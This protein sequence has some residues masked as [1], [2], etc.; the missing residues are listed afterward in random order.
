MTIKKAYE[1]NILL[2]FIFQ[3]FS[4]FYMIKVINTLFFQK[5]G[6]SIFQIGILLAIYQGSK[7]I[8]EVPTG[9]LADRYG[10]K[11]SVIIGLILFEIF[12]LATFCFRTFTGFFIAN[13]IQGI[14]ITFLTGALDAI[15]VDSA[16]LVGRKEKL[17]KYNSISRV[18]FFVALGLS[19]LIGGKIAT[20]SY[21]MVFEIT[22][23]IQIIPILLML[24]IKEPH[25]YEDII[26]KNKK[27]SGETISVKKVMKYFFKTPIILYF[28]LIDILISISMI[29]I[30]SYYSNYLVS[31]KLTETV[32]GAIIFG[33]Y[34]SSAL[35]GLFSDKLGKRVD[36]KKIIM[37]FPCLMIGCF[38]MFAAMNKTAFIILFYFL[39]L[40]VFSLFAPVKYKYFHLNVSSEYRATIGSIKS[41]FM[42]LVAVIIQ[43]VFGWMALN[44]G[45]SRSFVILLLISLS[46]LVINNIVFMKNIYSDLGNGEIIN[47]EL[48]ECL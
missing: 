17:S 35:V 7:F 41:L 8:F 16:I 33:Q 15:L 23:V 9:F 30:D 36:H 18:I 40:I 5:N 12:L 22:I 37:I 43:P 10:R 11:I 6:I 3:F 2:I 13:I 28:L 26:E 29:P 4:S 24:F 46:A 1:R 48:A 38:I 42:A 44:I 20:I 25:N 21:D 27:E 14:A 47:E 45:F 31:I 34:M 19:S 39:G 32:V